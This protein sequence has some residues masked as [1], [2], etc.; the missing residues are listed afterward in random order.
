MSVWGKFFS[1]LEMVG[2]TVLTAVNPAL[3]YIGS[4]IINN[5]KAAQQLPGKSGE[6]KLIFVVNA[7]NTAIDDLNK[8]HGSVLVDPALVNAALINGINAVIA[9]VKVVQNTPVAVEAVKAA[10]ITLPTPTK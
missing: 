4:D 9:T 6:E 3:G 10:D 2:P 8:A 5:I 1:V 7:S